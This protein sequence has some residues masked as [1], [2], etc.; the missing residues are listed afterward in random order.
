MAPKHTRTPARRKTK[1]SPAKKRTVKTARKS[2]KKITATMHTKKAHQNWIDTIIMLGLLALVIEMAGFIWVGTD[3]AASVYSAPKQIET[4]F[5]RQMDTTGIT[6]PKFTACERRAMRIRNQKRRDQV[7]TI[8]HARQ[9]GMGSSSSA[10][11]TPKK[12][13]WSKVF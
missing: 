4:R 12:E 8:C 3:Y 6:A 5:D 7:L 2:V 9:A 10:A 11:N 1:K 13:G